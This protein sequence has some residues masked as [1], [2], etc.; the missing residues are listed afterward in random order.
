[1]RHIA[2]LLLQQMSQWTS[3]RI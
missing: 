3:W 2:A 1:M